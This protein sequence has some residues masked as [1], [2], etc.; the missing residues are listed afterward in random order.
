MHPQNSLTGSHEVAIVIGLQSCVSNLCADFAPSDYLGSLL[1]SGPFNPQYAAGQAQKPPHQN[2]TVTVPS[3]ISKGAARVSVA[4]W[5]LIGVSA[6]RI[7]APR[8]LLK[9]VLG[10]VRDAL[11]DAHGERHH[12]LSAWSDFLHVEHIEVEWFESYFHN[13]TLRAQGSHRYRL[14]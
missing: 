4:H 10:L 2:F 5:S 8:P 14:L 7:Y 9:R 13:D 6:S 3:Y 1:Y 12:R 11:R